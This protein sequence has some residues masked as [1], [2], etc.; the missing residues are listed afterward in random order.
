MYSKFDVDKN[1]FWLSKLGHWISIFWWQN[2]DIFLRT[3]GQENWSQISI[4]KAN[5]VSRFSISCFFN[6]WS[7][8][9]NCKKQTFRP[10]PWWKKSVLSKIK[11]T[12]ENI[13]T[14][15]RTIIFFELYMHIYKYTLC[16]QKPVCQNQTPRNK[17][18]TRL[19]ASRRRLWGSW[20][21]LPGVAL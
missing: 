13:A 3:W 1:W 10:R 5:I 20:R 8:G 9:E 11:K 12:I 2:I 4:L 19:T 6:I 7:F 17:V 14:G 21:M 15:W 16:G 18:A